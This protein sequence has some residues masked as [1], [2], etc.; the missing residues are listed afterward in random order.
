MHDPPLPALEYVPGSHCVGSELTDEE[1]LDPA[2]HVVQVSVPPFEYD[3]FPQAIWAVA[4]IGAF[5]R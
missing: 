3:P 1:H 4:P 5:A 2:G